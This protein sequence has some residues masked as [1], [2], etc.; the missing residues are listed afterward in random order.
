M[1]MSGVCGSGMIVQANAPFDVRFEASGALTNNMCEGG[2]CQRC[3]Y[4]L[5]PNHQVN[6]GFTVDT[7]CLQKVN[8][9]KLRNTHNGANNDRWVLV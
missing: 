9:V 4:Y 8:F 3:R 6:Q 1:Y 5:A 2:A 7:G